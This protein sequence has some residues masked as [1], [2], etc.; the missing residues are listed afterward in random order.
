[1]E[2]S[3]SEPSL[4]DRFEVALEKLLGTR[5][6]LQ[7][8]FICQPWAF[9]EMLAEI[10]HKPNIVSLPFTRFNQLLLNCGR[11]LISRHFYVYFF[12][13][14]T[15]IE[16]FERSVDRFRVKAMWLFG[17]FE[18]ALKRLGG[19]SPTEF[20]SLIA[21]TEPIAPEKYS[22]REPFD[23]IEDIHSDDLELLGYLASKNFD[24]VQNVVQQLL[25]AETEEAARDLYTKLGTNNQGTIDKVL[26]IIIC[27]CQML[28]MK[29]N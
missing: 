29:K 16:D 8:I 24:M 18:F 21:K 5:R 17:N 20:E 3:A 14:V 12:D 2:N 11:G 25:T 6:D 9:E 22:A 4:K 15:T 27:A 28:T 23:E 7:P 1:M 26:G 19:S 10:L 13:G